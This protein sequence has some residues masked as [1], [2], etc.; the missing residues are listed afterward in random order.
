METGMYVH[1]ALCA[2]YAKPR[3]M[4]LTDG[5]RRSW[6]LHENFHHNNASGGDDRCAG[7]VCRMGQHPRQAFWD[8]LRQHRDAQRDG[9]RHQ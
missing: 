9:Y 1:G 5:Y 4:L 3:Q 7:W 8:R 6:V 2:E